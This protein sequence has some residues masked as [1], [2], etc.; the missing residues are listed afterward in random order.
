MLLVHP[1]TS[2]GGLLLSLFNELKKSFLF[3]GSDP[4]EGSCR[5]PVSERDCKGTPF[6]LTTK[7]FSKN[8]S[9]FFDHF[10]N[11]YTQVTELPLLVFYFAEFK[12]KAK[13][14][15]TAPAGRH[16]TANE[17]EAENPFASTAV[18][19]CFPMPGVKDIL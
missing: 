11:R 7:L 9:T 12:K 19:M 1:P 2:V 13:S 8:F 18:N 17:T 15:H 16:S 3:T 6:F 4:P 10:F 5:T 14:M